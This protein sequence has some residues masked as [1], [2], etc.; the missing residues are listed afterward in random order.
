LSRRVQRSLPLIKLYNYYHAKISKKP[1]THI[2]RPLLTIKAKDS[3][4]GFS[5]VE[6]N[7]KEVFPMFI[8]NTYWLAVTFVTPEM[9]LAFAESIVVAVFEIRALL[10]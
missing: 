4:A 7:D 2:T 3:S 8:A 10:T 6:L 9:S 5:R 1:I